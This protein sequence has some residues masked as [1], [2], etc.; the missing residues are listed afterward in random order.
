MKKLLLNDWKIKL[1]SLVVA[2]LLWYV[3]RENVTRDFER[4]NPQPSLFNQTPA[5][6]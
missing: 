4:Q 5:L 2:T 1:A 3:I 6:P